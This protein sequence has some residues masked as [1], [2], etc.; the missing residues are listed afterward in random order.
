MAV[1]ER[2]KDNDDVVSNNTRKGVIIAA[3][4]EHNLTNV[5]ISGGVA[6]SADVAWA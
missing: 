3:D 5:A 4:A 1:N 2:N 6:V